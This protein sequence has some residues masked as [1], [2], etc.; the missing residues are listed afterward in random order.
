MYAPPPRSNAAYAPAPGGGVT[1]VV[2][3]PAPEVPPAVAN[4]KQMNIVFVAAEMAPWSKTG[5]QKGRK[6]TLEGG[7]G[8]A[9]AG[10]EAVLASRGAIL[11]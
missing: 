5:G 8:G 11:G 2:L 1:I 10:F 4:G 7:L 3:E 9:E 6:S